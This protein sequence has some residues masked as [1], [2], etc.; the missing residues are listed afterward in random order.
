[1]RISAPATTTRSNRGFQFVPARALIKIRDGEPAAV[2]A[3]P[4]PD[5]Q[6]C[7]FSD[8]LFAAPF[9]IAVYE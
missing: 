5:S 7:S 6:A 9:T 3:M 8:I 2:A 1:M 4:P